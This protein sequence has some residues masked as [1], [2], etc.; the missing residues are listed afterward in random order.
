MPA[1]NKLRSTILFT[2]IV[3]MFSALS[4]VATAAGPDS[5]TGGPPAPGEPHELCGTTV[6]R[7]DQPARMRVNLAADVMLNARFFEGT[8]NF[9]IEGEGDYVGF[10]LSEVV[11]GRTGKTTLAYRGP[12]HWFGEPS[13]ST[14]HK[15][16][17]FDPA[18]D[19]TE[20]LDSRSTPQVAVPAG[21]YDLYLIAEGKP[22]TVTLTLAGLDGETEL[23]PTEP[24]NIR[25]ETVVPVS[26]QGNTS[27][28][29]ATGSLGSPGIFQAVSWVLSTEHPW[30]TAGEIRGGAELKGTFASQGR[31][32]GVGIRHMHTFW[33]PPLEWSMSTTT[34]GPSGAS[35]VH[36]LWLDLGDVGPQASSLDTIAHTP[37]PLPVTGEADRLAIAP[38]GGIRLVR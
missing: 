34:A 1:R 33:S 36:G 11:T 8:N 18:D 9:T 20:P 38:A 35:M 26:R 32:P 15:L 21:T 30:A 22:V 19:A 6:I 23:L 2:V 4:P 13:A 14:D 24:A 37:A 16:F 28:A 17:E 25:S 12:G 31:P 29:T 27:I 10:A 5:C 3:A 7:G